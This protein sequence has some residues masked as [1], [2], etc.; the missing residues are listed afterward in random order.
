MLDHRRPLSDLFTDI[1]EHSFVDAEDFAD[2]D[3]LLDDLESVVRLCVAAMTHPEFWDAPGAIDRVI[4]TFDQM[5]PLLTR[6]LDDQRGRR[7]KGGWPTD[8]ARSRRAP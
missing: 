8:P 2:P 7:I 3:R 1:D 6:L 4:D 5:H